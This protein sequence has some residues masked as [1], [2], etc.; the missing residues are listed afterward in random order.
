MAKGIEIIIAGII[1]GIV[2]YTTSILG[3]KG[4]VLGAVITS[5]L[6][7]LLS[8]FFKEPFEKTSL[9]KKS[10]K[11]IYLLPLVVIG[12]IEL[13]YLFMDVS[14]H[15]YQLFNFLESMANNNLFRIMGISLI[16]MGISPI[17][18]SK[19][20]KR[21][22]G[23]IVLVVGV[24]LSLRGFVDAD[25]AFVSLYAPLFTEYDLIITTFILFGL[26]FVIF[27]VVKEVLE[28]KDDELFESDESKPKFNK[29]YK[30]PKSKNYKK[31]K[32]GKYKHKPNY[33]TK[34]KA[35]SETHKRHEPIKS[36][37]N[38]VGD[39]GAN[40]DKHISEKTHLYYNAPDELDILDKE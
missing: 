3:I 5:I 15:S 2:A 27:K 23:L 35:N 19:A 38:Q 6:V 24:I 13:V 12:L 39:E 22:Y 8:N 16:L 4:T 7:E 36:D 25:F 31:F 30:K 10:V 26:G 21:E 40:P 18:R 20:I 32:N 9:R 37:S 33:Y 34:S 14:F 29:T 11:L 1:A 28:L 17:I